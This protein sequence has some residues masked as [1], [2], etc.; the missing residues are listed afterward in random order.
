MCTIKNKG[1]CR[2]C[3]R[4]LAVHS[5]PRGYNNRN[6]LGKRGG[7]SSAI[8]RCAPGEYHCLET[9]KLPVRCKPALNLCK[10]AHALFGFCIKS[11]MAMLQ[12]IL[13]MSQNDTQRSRT[14]WLEDTFRTSVNH[15]HMTVM[16]NA[17]LT[18]SHAVKIV[19]RQDGAGC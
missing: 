14:L 10:V 5:L 6:N 2:R 3:L 9:T 12:S 13:W 4:K 15:F 19:S 1:I 11:D 18:T 16:N 17:S 8:L 7:G